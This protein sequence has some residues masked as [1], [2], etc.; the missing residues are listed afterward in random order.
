MN[1]SKLDYEITACY[2]N[3]IKKINDK[4]DQIQQGRFYELSKVKSDG[5]L[6][7]NVKQLR[8]MLIDLVHKIQ[9]GEDGS[10]EKLAEIINMIRY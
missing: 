1:K 8:A 10:S 5:L 3:E 4:L 9:G 2:V 6:E 7:N